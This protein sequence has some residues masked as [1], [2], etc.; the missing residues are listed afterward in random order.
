MYEAFES[1][2]M[3]QMKLE[4]I[5]QSEVSQKEKTGIVMHIYGVQKD[6]ADESIHRAAIET[7]IE[8]RPWTWGE[9]EGKSGVHGEG[10]AGTYTTIHKTEPTGIGR[11]MHRT[12]TRALQQ[13]K[14]VGWGGRSEGGSK[15]RGRM[16]TYD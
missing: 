1:V 11:V 13:P 15:G 9:G 8:D 12:Q 5:M 14:G 7:D 3:K 2:L 10:R 16:Y 4:P 6:G